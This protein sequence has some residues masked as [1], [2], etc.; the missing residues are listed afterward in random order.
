M[1]RMCKSMICLSLILKKKHLITFIYLKYYT[2]FSLNLYIFLSYKP[3][4]LFFTNLQ[5]D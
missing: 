1:Q 5:T 4:N 2:F 3:E